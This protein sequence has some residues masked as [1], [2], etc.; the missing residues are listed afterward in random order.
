MG[1]PAQSSF[2][3]HN[4]QGKVVSVSKQVTIGNNNHP[5]LTLRIKF[6]ADGKLA[7]GL[8]VNISI[9]DN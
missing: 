6:A 8:P 9:N 2:Q 5:A 1:K 4:Y 7:A 3:Q